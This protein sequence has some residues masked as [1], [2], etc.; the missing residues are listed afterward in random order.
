MTLLHIGPWQ[1]SAV[2]MKQVQ[3]EHFLQ[4]LDKEEGIRDERRCYES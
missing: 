1:K 3:F 4:D 2:K